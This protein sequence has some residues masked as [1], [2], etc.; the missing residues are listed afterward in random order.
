MT[1]SLNKKRMIQTRI[2]VF[3]ILF[4]G[5]FCN[6]LLR[7]TALHE[8]ME[9]IGYILVGTCVV[10]RIYTSAFIGGFKNQ[11]LVTWGPYSLCRNPLYFCSYLGIL[12]LAFM[13]TSILAIFLAG[14]GVW[15]I[16]DQL[17]A[18]EEQFLK[19]TFGQAFEDYKNKVPRLLPS[20]QNYTC[21]EELA[22]RPKFL[23]KGVSDAA[24]WLLPLPLFRMVD[25][26]NLNDMI[27]M[28][29]SIL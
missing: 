14:I 29:V 7:D 28:K 6:T 16:Y 19:E 10:G 23:L 11:K 8:L 26:M 12:G 3:G 4:A 5:L 20:F 27:N 22:V 17:I 9:L 25:F 18:R 1:R 21:P 13:S 2:I 24:W 15:L